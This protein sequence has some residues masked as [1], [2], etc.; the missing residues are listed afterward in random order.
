VPPV[1]WPRTGGFR[2]RVRHPGRTTSSPALKVRKTDGRGVLGLEGVQIFPFPRP[3]RHRAAGERAGHPIMVRMHV[4]DGNL[5]RQSADQ[6]V[7]DPAQFLGSIRP[8]LHRV[9]LVTG[10]VVLPQ[11]D[12]QRLFRCRAPGTCR[13]PTRRL[14][15]TGPRVID[16]V[17]PLS[18]LAD[19]V[20]AVL[21]LVSELDQLRRVEGT[22]G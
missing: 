18:D 10:N 12:Q 14:L 21:H 4:G 20:R 16:L 11:V 3:H 13:H 17:G 19:D 6:A 7:D 9:L 5:E 8:R 1:L 22:P 2:R 15:S